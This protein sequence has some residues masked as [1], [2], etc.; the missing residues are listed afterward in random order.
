MPRNLYGQLESKLSL[1]YEGRSQ[2]D[3]HF[4]KESFSK[5]QSIDTNT[6]CRRRSSV[7]HEQTWQQLMQDVRKLEA[8]PATSSSTS[9]TRSKSENSVSG[10]ACKHVRWDDKPSDRSRNSRN[11]ASWPNVA[12]PPEKK[13]ADSNDVGAQ[14][15]ELSMEFTPAR[16]FASDK[17]IE[18]VSCTSGMARAMMGA[19]QTAFGRG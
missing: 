1:D 10:S 5:L 15:H 8:F 19:M 3:G 6:Q 14:K 17:P 9:C 2:N 16:S 12:N 11:S 18:R 7:V 13:F 4:L